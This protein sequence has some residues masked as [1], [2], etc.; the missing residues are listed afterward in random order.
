[1]IRRKLEDDTYEC[2]ANGQVFII[3]PKQYYLD[4]ITRLAET[5]EPTEEELLIFARGNH[6]YYQIS[7]AIDNL[8]NQL[9]EIENFE[10]SS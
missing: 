9:Q 6:P 8:N 4:E 1:M 3:P 7:L 2:E 10:A 5:P